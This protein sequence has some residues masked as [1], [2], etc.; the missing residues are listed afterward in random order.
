MSVKRDGLTSLWKESNSLL[1][2][3]MSYRE[4]KR[5]LIIHFQQ[6]SKAVALYMRALLVESSEP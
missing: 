2:L 5:Y 3:W 4:E 6:I 1:Q